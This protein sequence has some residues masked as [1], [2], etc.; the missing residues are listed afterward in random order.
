MIYM[1]Q[2]N[3]SGKRA[4]VRVDFNVPL[5]DDY[6]IL[7][8]TRLRAALPTIRKILK[9]GGAAILLSHLGRPK[10]GPEQRFSLRHLQSYLQENL[11]TNVHFIEDCVGKH[12]EAAAASLLMGE[13]LLLEN[14]RF[15]KEETKGDEAFA[16]ALARLAH[17][18]VNDA[19]GAAHRAHAST[20]VV[21]RYMKDKVCGYLMQAELENARRVMEHATHPFTAIVGGAKVSDKIL[22]IERLLDRVDNLLIGGGM[23]YTF[24]KAAGGQIGSSLLES[25]AIDLSIRLIETARQKGVNLLLPADSVV[26][27]AF[28][29]HANTQVVSSYHIPEAWMGLDIG[30]QARQQYYQTIVASKTIL[31][32]GP[33]GVFEMPPFAEGT[34]TIAEALAAATDA[35]A[36]T[37][38]GG[39]DSAAAINQMGFGQRVSYVS[40]GGGA[41]LELFEGKELPGVQA[42]G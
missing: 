21:A 18:Y 36:F 4:L 5:S 12:V 2:Y 17:V 42:L 31:W 16:Q 28:A 7:D 34:R 3:F 26:A 23:A 11:Q 29:A 25:E 33:V 39:G 1:D 24:I 9:D 10:S 20:T 19:F 13:V 6:R 14:V 40:T 37:L 8:D 15:Y 38:V 32:N 27:D 30:P 22:V 35:G 41:L